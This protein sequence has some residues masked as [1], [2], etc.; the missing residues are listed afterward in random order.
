M[1]T[2][3]GRET[4]AGYAFLM[5]A[6]IGLLVFS[7]GAIA[8]SLAASFT[9]WSLIAAPKWVGLANYR[10]AFHEPLFWKALGN[11]FYFLIGLPLAVVVPFT[12]AF[13]FNTKPPFFRFYRTAYYLPSVSSTVAI[14]LLWAWMY[15]RQFGLINYALS[16]VG[17]APIAWLSATWAKLS[18][19]LMSLWT[20]A[21]YTSII[22]LAGLQGIPQELYETASIDG[23]N[24]WQRLTRITIPLMTPTIF[25]MV[26]LGCIGTLQVFSQPFVM[27]GGGPEYA[28]FTIFFYIYQAGFT[29]FRMGYASSLAWVLFV[30]LMFFT[31]AQFRLERRWVF[32][33]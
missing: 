23:A 33:G 6:I 10:E 32:Y 29:F 11:S 27:T 2:R 22:Y 17:I 5:P 24:A 8:A 20:G 9:D 21:G 12:L 19:I 26:V 3:A 13:L 25:M 30:I 18:I 14:A 1:Q 15:N 16:Q 7:V 4:I 31:I 28:T